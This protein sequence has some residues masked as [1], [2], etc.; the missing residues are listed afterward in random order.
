MA[1][2]GANPPGKGPPG[3]VALAQDGSMAAFV[4]AG[5]ALTWQTTTASGEPVV[6]ERFWLTF[7]KGEIRVCTACHGVNRTDQAGNEEP[8]NPPQ[9]LTKLLNYWRGLDHAVPL[10]TP[11]ATPPRTRPTLSVRSLHGRRLGWLSVRRPF[12]LDLRGSP[13]GIAYTIGLR[14]NPP[15]CQISLGD[16]I[17]DSSGAKRIRLRLSPYTA[18]GHL[19]FIAASDIRTVARSNRVA[20]KRGRHQER[21]SG[22]PSIQVLGTR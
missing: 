3:S 5:R 14:Y 22:C 10:P 9:A 20:I 2:R 13:P 16:F 21:A 18:Q 6:R 4:P 19:R 1:S 17:T 11:G 12:V 7:K 8:T 15:G